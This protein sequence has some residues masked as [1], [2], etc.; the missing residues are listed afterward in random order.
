[1]NITLEEIPG[2]LDKKYH[3]SK[4][5]YVGED[6]RE[7]MKSQGKIVFFSHSLAVQADITTMK[8]S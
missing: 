7:L 8:N 3:E 5:Q 4:S 6:L 1:M 2:I